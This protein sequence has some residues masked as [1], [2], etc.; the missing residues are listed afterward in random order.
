[1][2][3][4]IRV[5]VK[6]Y[7]NW[8]KPERT[9]EVLKQLDV[10]AVSLANNHTMDFGPEVLDKTIKELSKAKIKWFGAGNNRKE[11]EK[12]FELELKG[13]KS[14]KKVYVFTG[15]R[16]S[17]RYREDYDFFARKDSPGV[18]SLRPSKTAEKITALRSK[19]PDAVII[20]CPHWQ[21]FDYKPVSPKIEEICQTFIDAGADF[22]FAHGTHTVEY[23]KK[24]EKGIIAHSI[25]NFVFNSPGRYSKL[26]AL[27]YSFI[28]KLEFAEREHGWQVE[29]RFYPI[30]TDNK[31]TNFNVRLAKEEELQELNKLFENEENISNYSYQIDKDQHG[32]FYI[33]H[34]NAGKEAKTNDDLKRIIFGDKKLSDVNFNDKNVL[35]SHIN[36]LGNLHVEID[37][38]FTAYYKELYG[39]KH[40]KGKKGLYE[41]YQ[42]LS[43]V[44]KK[45]YLS[46]WLLKNF[47]RRKLIIKDTFSFRDIVVEK[48]ALRKMG[49]PEYSWNLDK[50]D[51]AY[52]F[53]DSIGLRRPITDG[54]TYSFSEIGEQKG[55]VVVKPTKST[56]SMGVY[57]VFNEG[58]ILSARE[59][60]FLKSWSEVKK[61]VEAKLEAGLKGRNP[62][63]KDEWMT[64]ELILSS[65][66]ATEPPSDIKFYVFYGELLL[67]SESNPAF[68]KKFCY[69]D[70]DMNPVSTG[71]YDGQVF[72][73]T[74]FTEEDK[75]IAINVSLQI[76]TPFI[77]LDMLKSHT[78]MVLGE[79]TPR[80]G[81]FHSFNNE[82][83]R[84]LG[85]AYRRAEARIVK[86]LLNGKKF[87]AFT[88]LFNV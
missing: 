43:N 15:M 79:I 58:K 69:W 25:G 68:Y 49:Y 59:G 86:D 26:N 60:V 39:S 47:E 53:A 37:S 57:L 5:Q 20:V 84:K 13:D 4:A 74:G 73:G 40:L 30:V 33:F 38:N 82:F 87:A 42:S 81:R 19:E 54:K 36:Q 76:P 11:A 61:D 7:P 72:D 46:Y 48:S 85:E 63:R 56:G 31:K 35:E 66:G 83:D 71:R 28:V 70:A 14:T 27:P 75:E 29:P 77:R 41:L 21:G 9:L 88:D 34:T 32:F 67:V 22:V 51:V 6:E 52:K 2:C 65:P 10:T 1:M 55:P 3:P 17:K 16:A 62:L 44:V 8:D 64:E 23:I 50:K 45:E 78:G 24:S 12:P 80:P 18:N